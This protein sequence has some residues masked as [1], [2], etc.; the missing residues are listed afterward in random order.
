MRELTVSY[1][2]SR[3]WSGTPPDPP[4]TIEGVL[5]NRRRVA[6]VLREV[7]STN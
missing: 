1:H 5:R 4:M 7:D 6:G 3:D 2:K